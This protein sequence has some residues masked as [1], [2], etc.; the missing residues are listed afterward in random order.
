MRRNSIGRQA[1]I[2]LI[3][4]LS[5]LITLI[6]ISSVV[7]Y[8]AALH[9]AAIERAENLAGFYKTRLEQ[10]EHDWEIQSR[11]FKVRIEFTRAL[12]DMSS[13]ATNLQAF[14]TIQGTDRRFQ[15]LLI[16]TRDGQKLFDSGKD[17]SLPAIPGSAAAPIGHYLDPPTQ[18]LYR[19]FEYPIWLGEERGM[20]RFA[21]FFHID[22][23]LLVQ[24]GSPGVTL[25]AL[26]GGVAIASSG[27][28]T[29][30][31]R[32]RRGE[33]IDNSAREIRDLIWMAGGD[34]N[35][36]T[37]TVHLRIEAPI[38]TLFSTTELAV[39]MSIIPLV[40][41]LVLWFAIG[42]WLMRQARRITELGNAVGEFASSQQVTPALGDRLHHV[43]DRQADEIADVA[44]LM[45]AMMAAIDERKR[46]QEHATALLRESE[47]RIREITASLGDGVLVIDGAGRIEFVNPRAESLLGWSADE[48]LGRDSHPTLHGHVPLEECPVHGAIRAQ[49]EYRSEHENFACKNGSLLPVALSA[50]PIHR[51]GEAA[52]AVVAFQDITERLAAR[53]ALEAAKAEAEHANAAKSEFLANMSHEIRTPMNA[54]IGLSD[55]ALGLPGIGPK[56]RDYLSKIHTSSKALLSI[57]NDILDYS[58]VEAGRLELDSVEFR[59]EEMLLN[60]GDLFNVRAEQKGLEIVF[61]VAVDVPPVLIGDPLRLSQVLNN[62]VGNAVKFTESGEI[63]VKLARLDAHDDRDNHGDSAT[64]MFS[65]RDT[66]IGMTEEQAMRLFQPFTQA[67]GSITRRYGGTGLG[68]TISKRL[69]EKM[70]GEIMVDSAPGKGS[71]FGFAIPLRI[72]RDIRIERSPTDL[73]GMRV[74]V[75]D[76]LDISRQVLCEIL[77]AWGFNV[78]QAACG[79]EAIDLLNKAATEPGQEFEIILTDWKMP[80]M[81]GIALAQ[82][83][84][85]EVTRQ[86]LPRMPVIIMVTAFSKDQLMQ[87]AR[88]VELDAVL[89]KPVTSSG[90][91]DAIMRV[92]GGHLLED[93]AYAHS[94]LFE[95]A[96]PI[97]GA[98]LLLVEDNEINQ[99]VAQDLLERMGLQVTIA[100]DGEQAL[101][102]LQ[103]E[104]FDAVLMDLQMPVM[105]GFEATRR[106]RGQQRFAKLPVIAMTAAVL[107]RDREACEAAGMNDHVAKPIVPRDLLTVLLRWIKLKIDDDAARSCSRG[108]AEADAADDLIW[109]PATLPGFDLPNTLALMGGNRGLFKR[110]VLQFGE[111]FA[112]MAN[113][114]AQRLAAGDV[115]GAMALAH[116]TKGAAG[117]LGAT[118]LQRA[119]SLLEEKVGGSGTALGD[120]TSNPTRAAMVSF[121]V[122]LAEVL[123]SVAKLKDTKPLVPIAADYACDQCDWRR[124]NVLFGQLRNLVDNYDFVPSELLAELQASISCQP[125]RRKLETLGRHL[126]AT[127]YD[128]ARAL[129]GEIICREGHALGGVD[130]EPVPKID[131]A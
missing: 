93:A 7:I 40:D 11:D 125:L 83:V 46:A 124:A 129:L 67:D 115:A 98:H 18:A 75:V 92:Q 118:T 66:G 45:G 48:L 78:T 101:E 80:E 31:E 16:Q 88:G 24:M 81:D 3:V 122:A 47:A 71:C 96:A 69:V 114:M 55:L 26:H 109:L 12:E 27:G 51:D 107:S 97:R 33:I 21:M 60:V 58:K 103:L 126:D 123:E 77:R 35:N 38:T 5:L 14:M 62:L 2:R 87:A 49:R 54:I 128:S 116:K 68:L 39:G 64:L 23:A 90:L 8:R 73:R 19:V 108:F 119:A 29:A 113:E 65:V 91:F 6:S 15:Y 36:Q 37:S 10:I 30:L 112:G 53:Q 56:L 117:N 95:Q 13:A 25:S 59:V 61:D 20:G 121:N 106:I 32:L 89:T 131:P 63:H 100:S 28:Q 17:I 110:L 41:G 43:R 102:M 74:L 50:T 86:V 52:G 84:H 34:N 4:S 104:S 99:T 72:A 57:I 79:R 44:E 120:A 130:P 1:A 94:D 9:Q 127:D 70:G 82:E 111:Q 85:D 105:D 42:L 76:D 22:N